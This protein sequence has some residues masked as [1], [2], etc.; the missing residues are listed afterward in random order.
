MTQSNV[1]WFIFVAALGMFC[2]LIALDISNLETWEFMTTPKFIGKMLLNL[3]AVIS[4]F[5]GGKLLP[6]HE[7]REGLRTRVHDINKTDDDGKKL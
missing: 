6:N 2:G 7:N 4:A 5:I 1:G 3:S